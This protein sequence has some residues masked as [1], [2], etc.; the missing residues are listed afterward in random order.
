M[1]NKLYEIIKRFIKE[2]FIN[3]I[4]FIVLSIFFLFPL[5]YYINMP[6]GLL[7]TNDKIEIENEYKIKGSYNMTYVSEIKATP[8]LY[9]ITKLN[10]NWDLVSF[11]EVES[12]GLSLEEYK[13]YNKLLL[14]NAN[15]SAVIVA[16]KKA[17]KEVNII[18]NDFV[19]VHVDSINTDLE[20]GDII[21]KVDNI[22]IDNFEKIV[23]LVSSH[24]VGDIL[25]IEV[26]KDNKRIVKHAKIYEEDG[27]KIIGVLILSDISL[28][29]NPKYKYNFDEKESGPSGG[30]MITLTIYNKLLNYDLTKGLKI[31]GTGAIDI[32][33]NV[34]SI[35]GVKY[36]LKGAVKN[37]ADVF[38]VPAG[39]NYEEAIELQ[40]KY[41][42][43]ID[44]VSVSSFDEA[45]NYLKNK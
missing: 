14:N 31:S 35:G 5:P 12:S 13:V 36:K 38:L 40:K 30:L 7:N 32:N 41:N 2:N 42:Y 22:D 26:E 9:L 16:Y 3:F 11:K 19:V 45:V 44:I 37:K 10:K 33:G 43:N 29:A 39:E 27:R 1:F 17:L 18:K 4:V 23:E 15:D 24:K 6:G 34:S 21:R 8:I 28:S 20:A 25:N